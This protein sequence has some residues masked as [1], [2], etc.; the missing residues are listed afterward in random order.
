MLKNGSEYD[1]TISETVQQ[2]QAEK[3][4]KRIIAEA[5]KMGLIITDPNIKETA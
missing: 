5:K 2:K 3:H 1:E 4:K